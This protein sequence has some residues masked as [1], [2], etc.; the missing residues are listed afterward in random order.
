MSL[1]I[2]LPSRF[3]V[4]KDND[5]NGSLIFSEPLLVK[6]FFDEKYIAAYAFKK[7]I[8]S[9]PLLKIYSHED[10][11]SNKIILPSIHAYPYRIVGFDYKFIRKTY[12]KNHS[13]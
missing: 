4:T 6:T 12:E 1:S 11:V 9:S 2:K 10:F 7:F 3:E 8:N 5:F 13:Y